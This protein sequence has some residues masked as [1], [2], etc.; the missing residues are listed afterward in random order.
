MKILLFCAFSF[1]ALTLQAEVKICA[2]CGKGSRYMRYSAE[3]RYFC[4]ERCAK[5]KFG[6]FSCGNI[7]A[8]RYMIIMGTTGENR[9]YCNSCKVKAER[10]G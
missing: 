4:S 7:P 10:T 6:C 1:L 9:R 8:G 2:H 3:N 5:A